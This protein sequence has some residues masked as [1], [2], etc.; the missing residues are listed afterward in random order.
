[1]QNLANRANFFTKILGVYHDSKSQFFYGLEI[2]ETPPPKYSGTL[3]LCNGKGFNW[4]GV[5]LCM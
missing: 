3:D 1:M 5:L 2:F 4:G